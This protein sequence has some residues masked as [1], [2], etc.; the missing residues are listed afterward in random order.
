M[1]ELTPRVST[2]SSCCLFWF[3]SVMASSTSTGRFA[4]VSEEERKKLLESAVPKSTKVAT[5]FWLK[6]FSDFLMQESLSCDFATVEDKVLAEI[7]ERF[8]C[9]VRTHDKK[10]YKRASLIAARGALQREVND[11]DRGFDLKRGVFVKANKLLDA[12]LKDK[13]KGG[14]EAPVCHKESLSDGDWLLIKEYFAD[15]MT[16][17]DPRKLYQF[18]WFYITLQFCL[19]GN[20]AHT[21]LMKSDLVF[22]VVEGEEAIVLRSDF[23]SKNHQGGLG[24]T[25]TV[26]R[27]AIAKPDI[28][29]LY[30]FREYS[31]LLF[32]S[33]PKT[34]F[35]I[36]GRF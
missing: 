2:F 9:S 10:E 32:S 27:G 13:K 1:L 12:V 20:E 30:C 14:R 3:T 31:Y 5:K 21:E 35:F 33:T 6:V 15:G 18:V 23:M 26:T 19:R 7:L 16:T 22:T 28:I 4:S 17:M 25:E 29:C 8:Y 36:A 11:R 24:G 34:R